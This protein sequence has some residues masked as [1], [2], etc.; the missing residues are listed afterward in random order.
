MPAKQEKPKKTKEE[1]T[2]PVCISRP[3]ALGKR[4]DDFLRS[5]SVELKRDVNH[6]QAVCVLEELAME[7]PV[8][9]NLLMKKLMESRTA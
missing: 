8:V 5:A 7:S 2:V 1:K 4:F 9:E 6:S 3:V